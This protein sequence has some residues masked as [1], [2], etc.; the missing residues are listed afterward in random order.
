MLKV[1]KWRIILVLNKELANDFSKMNEL[2]ENCLCVA[3]PSIW[4]DNMPNSI[5]EAFAYAKPVIASNIGSIKEMVIEGYNG[6]LF[7]PK[8]INQIAKCIMMILEDKEKMIKMGKN[9]RSFC[10]EKYS[11]AKHL[12]ALYDVFKSKR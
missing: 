12:E 10:E 2:L 3:C 8:S 6:F 7:E 5:I 11:P 1:K 4:F 9:A